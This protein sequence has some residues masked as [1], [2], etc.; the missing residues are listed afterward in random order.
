MCDVSVQC[1]N[2]DRVFSLYLY[3]LGDWVSL[4]FNNNTAVDE[5]ANAAISQEGMSAFCLCIYKSDWLSD[6]CYIVD[7]VWVSDQGVVTS[8]YVPRKSA[9]GR[10]QNVWST[11]FYLELLIYLKMPS[12]S[13]DW[14]E[15]MRNWLGFWLRF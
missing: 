10:D 7:N 11:K 14:V 5:V 1:I 3:C 12:R 4:K 6:K 9:C 2:T 8:I 13:F 15:T